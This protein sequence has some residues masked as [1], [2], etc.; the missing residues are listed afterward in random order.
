MRQSR[1]VTAAQGPLLQAPRVHHA[2]QMTP[3][4]PLESKVDVRQPPLDRAGRGPGLDGS[5]WSPDIV[6]EAGS[7][8]TARPEKTT[9]RL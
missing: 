8:P 6:S 7:S 4:L 3:P 5:T 2:C 9:V 1:P